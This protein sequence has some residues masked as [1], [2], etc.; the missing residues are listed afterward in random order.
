MARPSI[1][2][3]P[4]AT[5]QVPPAWELRAAIEVVHPFFAEP[6]R[7]RLQFEP[8][9][10]ASAWI[11]RAGAIA[12]ARHHEWRLYLP[13]AAS[14]TGEA[15][16]LDIA[17]SARDPIFAAVTQGLAHADAPCRMTAGLSTF[18]VSLRLAGDRSD[19]GRIYRVELQARQAVWKYILVG[20]WTPEQPFI[21]D[22]DGRD[23]FEPARPEIV[24]GGSPALSIRSLA[25][26]P[27][28]ERSARRF[29]LRGRTDEVERVL[30]RRLAVAS[31]AQWGPDTADSAAVPVSE[32][33]VQR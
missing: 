24:A 26:I 11:W 23:E 12:R 15:T 30:V 20:D 32:I 16:E 13:V 6:S 17:V 1:T 28:Q 5:R 8:S 18:V 3:E 21:V 2:A 10:E 31:A 4:V 33:Y 14:P 22:L 27:L 9:Q 7:C 29:Q 19:V 25:P